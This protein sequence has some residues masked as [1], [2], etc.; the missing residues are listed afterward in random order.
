MAFL[1]TGSSGFIG[2]NF[3]KFLIDILA[4][5]FFKVFIIKKNSKQYRFGRQ[6]LKKF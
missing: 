3:C 6:R 4:F 1:I 2:T 5:I